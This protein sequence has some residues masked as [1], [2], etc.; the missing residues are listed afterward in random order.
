VSGDPAL[1][2]AANRFLASMTITFDMWHDGEGYDLA[3]LAEISPSE[4]AAIESILIHHQPRDW[5][6]IEALAAFDSA[7]ARE[8][9]VAALEHPDPQ[10]RHEAMRHAGDRA[11]PMKREARLIDALRTRGLYHG[12]SEAIDE[13]A[14]FHPAGVVEALLDG[15]LHRDG[16]AAVHFAALLFFLHGKA[17]E[18]FDWGQRPFFL[19]F[20]TT[21]RGERSAVFRV[22][23]ATI[24]VD[25]GEYLRSGESAD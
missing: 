5:R 14:E 2:E 7:T 1:G 25:A 15:A 16:E 10:V 3:A 22:L 21:D 24:G 8:A 20:Q 12:L 6:D 9:I 13:A 18:P 17:A 11:D 4:R 19:R 23:C